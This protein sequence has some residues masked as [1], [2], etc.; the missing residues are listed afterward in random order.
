[1]VRITIINRLK[2]TDKE[3]IIYLAGIVDGEG[4][5]C[6]PRDVNGRGEHHYYPVLIVVQK[7][8]ELIEWLKNHYGGWM[9]FINNEYGGYYRWV[10]KGKKVKELAK[11]MTPYLIVKREQVKRVL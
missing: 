9:G 4:H 11:Q 3:K 7:D 10:L 8:I 1:M 6:F 5:F 2:M